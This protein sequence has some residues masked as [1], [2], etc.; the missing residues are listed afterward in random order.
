MVRLSFLEI[1]SK[2]LNLSQNIWVVSLSI[3]PAFLS[4]Q[5]SY[6]V[7]IE[8]IVDTIDLTFE[9]QSEFTVSTL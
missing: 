5:R 9:R 3:S 1:K 4:S 2:K 8:R 7:Y 6:N